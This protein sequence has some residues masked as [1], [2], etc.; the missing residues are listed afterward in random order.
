MFLWLARVA[1]SHLPRFSGARFRLAL[2]PCRN[3]GRFAAGFLPESTKNPAGFPAFFSR[4]QRVSVCKLRYRVA[5][6]SRRKLLRC[7]KVAPG[8]RR[9][10]PGGTK[11]DPALSPLRKS[12]VDVVLAAVHQ[13]L[14]GDVLGVIVAAVSGVRSNHVFLLVDHA[15]IV[16]GT[17]AIG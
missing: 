4:I 13:V 7:R 15:V 6:E 8:F 9:K 17:E 12:R 11:V 2:E 5:T 10:S 16:L 3:P 1:Q 14:L